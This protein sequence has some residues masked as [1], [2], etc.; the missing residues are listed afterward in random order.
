MYIPLAVKYRP[1]RFADVVGQDIIV[2]IL[3]Q[4]VL[5]G[6]VGSAI[7]FSGTRGVGKT[8]L[9]RILAKSLRCENRSASEFEPCCKCESCL[10]F[11]QNNQM[12][13]IEIDAASNTGVDDIRE[14]IE[15]CRYKPASGKYK[16]FIIDEVHMLSKSAFNALLKTLEEPPEHVKFLM[17]TT[18]TYKIPETILSR[19]LKFDLKNVGSDLI[20]Q[21]LSSVCN[22]ENISASA[23]ALTMAARYAAGSIRDSLTILDQAVNLSDNGRLDLNNVREILCIS[24]DLDLIT[25]FE[26]VLSGNIRDAV[27]KYREIISRGAQA[28]KVISRLMD[29]VYYVSCMKENVEYQDPLSEEYE[30]KLKKISNHI[31]LASLSRIWQMLLKGV[32]E[33]KLCERPDIAAEMLIMRL[34]YATDFPD[35][36]DFVKNIKKNEKKCL[37]EDKECIGF[38]PKK[39]VSN[40]NGVS[41][42][43]ADKNA[44]I[45]K[46]F[47]KDGK[48]HLIQNSE[49]TSPGEENDISSSKSLLDAALQIFPE[50][51]L[52][53]EV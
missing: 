13:V 35:L 41:G 10:G 44:D 16:I 22:Q 3:T 47:E 31:S 42:L 17:A 23:D 37:T 50:A 40:F 34:A 45:D 1:Q 49:D 25:M 52:E 33:L 18:E 12:D 27:A 6:R 20:A 19:V 24:D 53:K 7:L 48:R 4:A 39:D 51:K 29:Y 30:S 11:L 14:I 2:K 38:K 46:N 15:N 32:E 36:R 8:T 26:T 43:S 28:A 5:R 9:A 21:Y